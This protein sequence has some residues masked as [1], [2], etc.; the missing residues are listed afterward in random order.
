VGPRVGQE[1]FQDGLIASG[2]AV[3]MIALD[4]A[5]RVEW[6]FGISALIATF[7]DVFVTIGLFSILQLDFN[8][9]AI[10]CL[11]T[12][13]GYSINDTVVVF[14]RMRENLRRYKRADL[15]TIINMSVNQTL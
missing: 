3:L 9:T 12:L 11:L 7:H 2:L 10:A 1:L 15:K 5:F 4:V 14:D 6:Q 13:A 8:L